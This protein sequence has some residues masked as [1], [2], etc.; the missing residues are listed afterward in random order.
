MHGPEVA[1]L[2][3]MIAHENVQPMIAP[4]QQDAGHPLIVQVQSLVKTEQAPLEEYLRQPQRAYEE[5]LQAM[6]V[7]PKKLLQT[8]AQ[9]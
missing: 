1:P 4:A 2:R 7:R 8:C 6:R 5:V 3:G 9:R